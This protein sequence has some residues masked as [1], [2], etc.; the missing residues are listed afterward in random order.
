MSYSPAEHPTAPRRLELGRRQLKS[1]LRTRLGPRCFRLGS[2]P[3]LLSSTE[4]PVGHRQSAG[5]TRAAH[6]DQNSVADVLLHGDDGVHCI[7]DGAPAV[8]ASRWEQEPGASTAAWTTGDDDQHQVHR[9]L[10]DRHQRMPGF[11]RPAA[12]TFRNSL[13][14]P[15][16]G[17]QY[18]DGRAIGVFA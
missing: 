8:R 2:P 18:A 5:P 17:R 7:P 12:A 6:G 13:S 14:Q 1:R 15:Q 9:L 16:A 4:S 10:R 11:Q 3:R